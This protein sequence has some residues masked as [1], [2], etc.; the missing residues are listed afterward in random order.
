MTVE[1][2][3]SWG[4]PTSHEMP[5]KPLGAE[6]WRRLFGDVHRERL[7]GLLSGAVV[8]GAL[9]ATEQQA[10]E[11]HDEAVRVASRLL[12]VE[13][14]LLDT[15]RVLDDLEVEY[16]VLKGAALAHSVYGDP[17]YRSFI[18]VDL[19]IRP[20]QWYATI[21]ALEAVGETR[22][23]PELRPGFDRRFGKEATLRSRL[24]VEVDLH[25]TLV[26]GP[27][28]LTI[29]LPVLFGE[30]ACF[31]LGG[32]SLPMLDPERTLLFAAL[33]AAI[34]DDP[35]RLVALRDVAQAVVE[36][37]FNWAMTVDLAERWALGAAV[38][39]GIVSTWDRLGLTVERPIVEWARQ[40]RAGRIERMLLAGYQG[41]GTGYKTHLS[42]LLVLRGRD[43]LDYARAIAF[44]QRSYLV[45]RRR[46]G[47]SHVLQSL[48]AL[49]T[50]ECR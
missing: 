32:R 6:A 2:V 1:A 3:A 28:G 16:R 9:P 48:R 34:G 19:L 25:R 4:L 33:A 27:L 35:P 40:R 46:T 22:V 30:P 7:V 8:A 14:K 49:A 17:F 38:A 36:R 42:A 31:R 13:R 37:S 45:A 43:R 20:E 41:G 29:D 10:A 18:D 47:V 44:P 12:M 23:L 15:A 5:D 39:R 24:G 26:K 50:R 21:L 11:V